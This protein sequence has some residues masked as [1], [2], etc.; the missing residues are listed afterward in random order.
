MA[1][2]KKQV[3]VP[4]I[5]VN[6]NEDDTGLDIRVDLAGASKESVDLDVGDKG[7]CIKAEAEDFRYE[8]CFMLAHEIKRESAKAKFDSGLLRISVPFKDT[9]H[10]HKVTVE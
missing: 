1:Q 8:N 9:L 6:H 2:E 7:F 5:N 3:V 10:G 4:M